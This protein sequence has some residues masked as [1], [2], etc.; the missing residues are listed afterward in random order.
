MNRSTYA[1]LLTAITALVLVSA[2]TGIFAANG[3]RSDDLMRDAAAEFGI[4]VYAGLISW[5]GV[6]CLVAT[7]AVTAFAAAL[8]TR[9]RGLLVTVAIFSALLALDDSLMLHESFSDT[10]FKR[11]EDAIFL[12]YAVILVGIG[13]AL[14]RNRPPIGA[15]GILVSG[16]LFFMSVWL[17]TA[18]LGPVHGDT[19]AWWEDAT[20]FAGFAAWLAYWIA[21]SRSYLLERL[22]PLVGTSGERETVAV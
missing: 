13:V 16:G 20:K 14:H 21:A 10:R 15:R 5:L 18:G 9:G 19:V 6:Y 12:A 8:I 11:V 22:R 2:L 4:P 7:V 17:D 3:V 1:I